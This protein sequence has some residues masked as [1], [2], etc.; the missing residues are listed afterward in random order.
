MHTITSIAA[1]KSFKS[2]RLWLNG[3]EIQ[4]NGRGVTCLREIR[5][6]AGDRIDEATGE[7]L[8]R[9]EDWPEYHVHISS[10]NTFPTGAGLAS[11]AAG[12]ACFVATLADENVSITV[13]DDGKVNNGLIAD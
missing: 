11:S 8:V 10:V 13:R 2:D 9:K 4:I 6:L 1:S 7:V 12:L 3:T 5:R